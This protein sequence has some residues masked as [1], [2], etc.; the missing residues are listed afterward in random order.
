MQV[1]VY[2][3]TGEAKNYIDGWTIV[4]P[5]S[6]KFRAMQ[7]KEQGNYTKAWCLGC[8][9]CNGDNKRFNMCCWF[10]LDRSLG[11]TYEGLGKR[12]HGADIPAAMQAWIKKAEKAFNNLLNNPDDEKA[13]LAWANV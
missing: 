8:S 1:K 5:L 2:R 7:I 3:A 4:F 13:Q 6:K 9:P 11:Y 10:D 12:V